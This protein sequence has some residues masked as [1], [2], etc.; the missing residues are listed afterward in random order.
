M[1][2]ILHIGLSSNPG[3]VE[4]LLYNYLKYINKEQFQFDF[5]DIYNEGLAFETEMRSL[6]ATIIN[7]PNYKKS[8]LQFIERF[9]NYLMTNSYDIIHIHMQSAANLLPIFWAKRSGS[10]VIC[11]SHSSSTPKGFLRKFL[12]KI[13]QKYLKRL[14]IVKW[15]CGIQ[16]GQWMWGKSFDKENVIPNAID[17]KKFI[18]NDKLRVEMRN[19]L[20]LSNEDRVLGFVGRFGDEKNIFFLLE[21]LEELLKKS[22][23][24]KLVC[25]GDGD[26]YQ[27][28]L[29]KVV[30]KNLVNNVYCV[31][32]QHNTASWYQLFDIFLLPSFFEGFPVVAVE[33]QASN[34]PCFLSNTIA[35][36]INLSKNIY[37]LPLKDASKW[38]TRIDTTFVSYKRSQFGSFDY[39]YDITQAISILE[40]KYRVLVRKE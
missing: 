30:E 23:T 13:N 10:I 34:I 8:P 4:N 3:G 28:F 26:L 20:K 2:K 37:F 27:E 21:I 7:F 11:H 22:N 38:S 32:R 25:V 12:N 16:A 39:R 14:D 36:E 6:G 35:K 18:Y 17:T 33:A 15:A 5:A 40:N 9:N 29:N 19:K 1:I 24:Y 31:G